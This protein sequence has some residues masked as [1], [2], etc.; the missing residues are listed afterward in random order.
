MIREGFI[1]RAIR[2]LRQVFAQLLGKVDREEDPAL[3]DARLDDLYLEHLGIS[4]QMLGVLDGPSQ[5]RLLSDRI[6]VAIELVRGERDLLAA[7][8]RAAE[9]EDAA[10]RLAELEQLDV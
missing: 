3:L 9:A 6:F 7:A 4:R 2:Q 1:E 8:G 5:L 10:R